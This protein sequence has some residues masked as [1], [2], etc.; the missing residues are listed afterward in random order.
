VREVIVAADA[1]VGG[2]GVRGGA[3]PVSGRALGEPAAVDPDGALAG[4][5]TTFQAMAAATPIATNAAT[6]ERKDQRRSGGVF[7][8]A[9]SRPAAAAETGW[10]GAADGAVG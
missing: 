5:P 6:G 10:V 7:E 1:L 9:S 4:G 2:A 3:P 8:L